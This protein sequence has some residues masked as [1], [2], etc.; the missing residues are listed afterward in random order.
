MFLSR[1][2]IRLC[3]IIGYIVRKYT[4]VVIFY[5]LFCTKEILKRHIKDRSKIN[6]I[7]K[8]IMPKK[9]E[10]NNKEILKEK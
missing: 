5:K 2:L 3:M 9:V 10:Y 6:D 8:I 4:F 1:I 7:E